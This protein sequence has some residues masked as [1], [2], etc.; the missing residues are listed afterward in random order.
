MS[1]NFDISWS[2]SSLD[3]RTDNE[4]LIDFIKLQPGENRMR[5]VS[6]PSKLEI[7]WE[8]T[9][10]GSRRKVICLGAKCPVCKHSNPPQV[11]YQFKV[12]DREDNK[13]KILEC[14]KQIISAIRNYA[15]DSDYGDPTSYDIKIKK[16]GRGRDTKYTVKAVPN[17]VPLTEE[18]KEMVENS[19]SI[20]ELNKIKTEEEIYG[21]QL[22][23]LA[24]SLADLAK[25]D[26]DSDNVNSDD[27]DPD[28]DDL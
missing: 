22:R 16:D 2:D 25:D 17:K 21:L 24:D 23:V 28:W 11:R 6:Q 12:I 13:V 3:S 8:D 10:D 20:A 9:I 19:P 1:S 4:S 18:E 15:V 27:N 5:I 26:I 7:H 14:G